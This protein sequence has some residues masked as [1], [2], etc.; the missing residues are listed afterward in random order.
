MVKD[1]HYNRA[2][3]FYNDGNF[4]DA[5]DEA[6]KALAIDSNYQDAQQLLKTINRRK[7]R[8]RYFALFSVAVIATIL[9][10]VVFRSHT[11]SKTVERNRGNETVTVQE[12]P[13]ERI[14]HAKIGYDHIENEEYHQAIDALKKAISSDSSDEAVH[15]SLGFAY[16][17]TQDYEAAIDAFKAGISLNPQL[18]HLH[19]NLGW[20]YFK[21]K[22]LENAKKAA[23]EALKI[24]PNYES[25]RELLEAISRELNPPKLS[26]E[27]IS[28]IEPSGEG[29]LDAGEKAHLKFTVKNSGGTAHDVMV[30]LKWDS[31]VGLSYK[32]QTISTLHEDKSKTIQIPIIA[33]RT[34]KGKKYL[35][36]AIQLIEKNGNGKLLVFRT[37]YFTT[38]P[39]LPKPIR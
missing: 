31:I 20:A 14:D 18:K 37:F 8:G 9:I 29:F 5:K 6:E 10:F 21:V 23:E 38:R 7:N 13:T 39:S 28:L 24:D 22:E 11:P 35:G 15:N 26:I 2:K 33:S 16:Y 34:I 36:V 19:H 17:S 1:A 12:P 4:G 32:P 3:I 27:R 25:T 30:R